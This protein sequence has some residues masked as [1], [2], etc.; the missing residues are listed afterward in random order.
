MSNRSDS[1]FGVSKPTP[2]F[3]PRIF[4]PPRVAPSTRFRFFSRG[5]GIN[6]AVRRGPAARIFR[7]E[8]LDD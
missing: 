2:G 7:Y 1:R 5:R 8:E 4:V 6:Q 3:L